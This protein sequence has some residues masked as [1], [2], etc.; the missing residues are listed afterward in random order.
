MAGVFLET[1]SVVVVVVG[2]QVSNETVRSPIW[3]GFYNSVPGESHES[4]FSPARPYWI[5]R[6]GE[7]GTDNCRKMALTEIPSGCPHV[8]GRPSSLA[9]RITRRIVTVGVRRRELVKKKKMMGG[10]KIRELVITYWI[11]SGACKR[12]NALEYSRTNTNY[13][14]FSADGRISGR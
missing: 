6:D 3:C 1:G 10:R 2:S 8:Q 12:R 7:R 11:I 13:E 4:L 14:I 9:A 5:M